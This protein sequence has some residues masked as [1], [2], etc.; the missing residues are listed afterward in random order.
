[1]IHNALSTFGLY[2]CL[3]LC[4]C[5]CLALAFGAL[6]YAFFWYESAWSPFRET[7]DR[8]FHGKTGRALIKTVLLSVTSLMLVI[9]FYPLAYRHKLWHPNPDRGCAL[10]PV[11]LVHGLYHNSS[12]WVLYRRWLKRSGFKNV[13]AFS[14][15]SWKVS[16]SDLLEELDHQVT[17]LLDLFPERQVVLIGHSLGGL[18]SRAYVE[19]TGNTGKVGAVVTLGAPHQGSKLAAL[20]FG[21]L[22]RSLLYRGALITRLETEARAISVPRLA[23][24]SPLDN[25]V[26]PNEALR[27]PHAGWEYFE[28]GPISHIGMLFHK[29]SAKQACEYIRIRGGHESGAET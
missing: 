22:A 20:G 2:F 24:H 8:R 15:S 3:C 14:Y 18:L 25:M 23:I 26:L 4:L 19:C 1:M 7:L 21:K 29:P 9:V 28:S 5:L 10:P 12:A 13:Y 6:T 27:A 11:L 17:R 16:F